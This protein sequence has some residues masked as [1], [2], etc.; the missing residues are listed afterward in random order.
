M[1]FSESTA[2]LEAVGVT[3]CF[4]LVFFAQTNSTDC[5]LSKELFHF[6]STMEVKFS[7][8]FQGKRKQS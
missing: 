7:N 4:G 6:S 5:N 8:K 3:V 1:K 2:V